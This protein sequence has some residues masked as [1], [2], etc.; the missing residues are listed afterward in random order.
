[1][2]RDHVDAGR[3]HL[4]EICIGID[5]IVAQPR[6]VRQVRRDM[7]DVGV[8]VRDVGRTGGEH[9]DAAFERLRRPQPEHRLL[10]DDVRDQTPVRV[11]VRVAHGVARHEHAPRRGDRRNGRA[12][13]VEEHEVW[14]QLRR[15]PR[16]LGDVRDG[17]PARE[18]TA[19]S[20]A[21]DRRYARE[22]GDL[23]MVGRGVAPSVGTGHELLD[24]RRSLDQLG[25]LRAAAAHRDDD[26]PPVAREEARQVGGDRGLPDALAGADHRDRRQLERLERRWVEP[27]VGADVGQPGGQRPRRPLEPLD[28]PE[29][30]LVGQVDHHLGRREPVDK[31]HAVVGVTFAELLGTPHEDRSLP[32]VGER[33]ESIAHDRR[34]MLPVDERDGPHRRAVT[35]LSIRPVYFSYSPVD[36]S[37]WMIRSCPWNGYRRHTVTCDPSISTTL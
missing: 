25:L 4:D 17:D 28:R 29:H 9:G 21:A 33:L 2:C 34:V 35:S 10:D 27:E 20:P 32:V 31:W 14:A 19:R 13:P 30:R 16:A 1:M 11:E 5:E 26:H 37:N 22:R 7:D 15:E 8:E 18:P 23:Q 36:T 3:L 24:G 12:A 6:A